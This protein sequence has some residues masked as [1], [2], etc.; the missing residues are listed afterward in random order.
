MRI[1]FS[2]KICEMYG[3]RITVEINQ[4]LVLEVSIVILAIQFQ[5]L[6]TDGYS[7]GCAHTV[8]PG[9]FLIQIGVYDN[10]A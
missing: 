8:V 2:M 6:F 9:F 7:Q 10:V 3:M 5:C 4:Q 1:A